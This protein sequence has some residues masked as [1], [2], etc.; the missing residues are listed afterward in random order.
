MAI[1]RAGYFYQGA[2]PPSGRP[3]PWAEALLQLKQPMEVPKATTPPP[4]I[5]VT[6]APEVT[7]KKEESAMA[8]DS[9]SELTPQQ[10]KEELQ[11]LE[12][13]KEA[14]AA[15]SLGVPATVTQQLKDLRREL[16]S[17]RPEGRQLDQSAAKVCKLAAQRT[18][19]EE[20]IANL[21]T[22]LKEAEQALAEA[23]KEEEAA[24][25]EHVR[26]KQQLTQKD[27][28]LYLCASDIE[29]A[30][31]ALTVNLSNAMKDATAKGCQV[32]EGDVASF[33]KSQLQA[34]AKVSQ[35][36]HG[37]DAAGGRVSTVSAADAT[38]T[39]TDRRGEAHT[40]ACHSASAR[41]AIAADGTAPPPKP[42]ATQL[43]TLSQQEKG[44]SRTPDR[45]NSQE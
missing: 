16:H 41:R 25:Q 40:G 28:A 8:G 4:A 31:A 38:S 11:R 2:A 15:T 34:M 36:C 44:R 20:T 35:G 32:Q 39:T 23:C 14:L 1:N 9:P 45:D 13:A 7:A 6:K 5:T 19:Q 21:R 24:K 27:D 12:A 10:L 37:C 30:A 29:Q 43:D 3:L 18:K 17:R 33:I 42:A 26:V 22:Q